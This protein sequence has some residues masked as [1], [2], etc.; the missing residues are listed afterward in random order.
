MD[1]FPTRA[2]HEATVDEN[3]V[4]HLRTRFLS[5]DDLLAVVH[6][7]FFSMG[8]PMLPLSRGAPSVNLGQDHR[9]TIRVSKDRVATTPARPPGQGEPGARGR[10]SA[11]S[12]A[13]ADTFTRGTILAASLSRYL[14]GSGCPRIYA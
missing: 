11:T 13:R 3:Y 12:L 6:D 8:R 7:R 9:P 4:H 10:A 14:T 5:H 2:V 1:P